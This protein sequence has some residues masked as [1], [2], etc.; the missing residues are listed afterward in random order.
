M[1]AV[2]LFNNLDSRLNTNKPVRNGLATGTGF[3][4]FNSSTTTPNSALSK[5]P[6]ESSNNRNSIISN[7]SI[8]LGHPVK[9][10]T[11]NGL[12]GPNYSSQ[13]SNKAL[14]VKRS[15]MNSI[16]SILSNSKQLA[17]SNNSPSAASS[18]RNSISSIN[19]KSSRSN[20]SSQIHTYKEHLSIPS[21]LSTQFLHHFL[22]A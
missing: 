2:G 11:T 3:G 14:S 20:R 6:S 22:V 9:S 1:R 8:N 5:A 19:T 4:L 17:N 21:T 12:S 15:S 16:S 7:S 13:I 18:N 10:R